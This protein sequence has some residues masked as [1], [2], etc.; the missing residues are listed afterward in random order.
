MKKHLLQ[1]FIILL[2]VVLS[3]CN[4]EDQTL[5]NKADIRFK[6][7]SS[8]LNLKSVSQTGTIISIQ[9]A[10]IGVSEIELEMEY[11]EEYESENGESEYEYEYEVEYEIEIRGP[12]TVDLIAAT[13]TPEIAILNIEQ[14]MYS[15]F[16]C[17]IENV[18]E[19]GKSVYIEGEVKIDGV[20]YTFIFES[21]E[22]FE[23]EIEGYEQFNQ[24]ISTN[25]L[26][27]IGFDLD[28]LFLEANFENVEIGENDIIVIS[29]TSNPGIY[30]QIKNQLEDSFDFED[31]DH[32]GDQDDH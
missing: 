12:Y 2:A 32:Q 29:K 1:F 25:E 23:I 13:S 3:S 11:E 14:G 5:D 10:M 27:T 9:T 15:E 21:E 19:N 26:W 17:E 4:E 6:A 16:E 7:V 28:N 8:N 18:M 30:G 20:I 22:D 24:P 31:D